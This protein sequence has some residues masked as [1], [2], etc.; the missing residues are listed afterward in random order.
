MSEMRSF[1]TRVIPAQDRLDDDVAISS[2]SELV[3]AFE[4]AT[5]LKRPEKHARGGYTLHLCVRADLV[6]KLLVHLHENGYL[7]CL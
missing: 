1:Y 5:M 3:E 2:V 7:P 4:S 6:E